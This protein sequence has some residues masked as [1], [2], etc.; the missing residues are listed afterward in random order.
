MFLISRRAVTCVASCHLSNVNSAVLTVRYVLPPIEC[1][2]YLLVI[3]ALESGHCTT[4]LEIVAIIPETR[5]P[6]FFDAQASVVIC[7]RKLCTNVLPFKL[8]KKFQNGE[9][10][11]ISPVC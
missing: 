5:R 4:I 3:V 10:I 8:V 6:V 7:K 9:T 2:W 1:I 11:I